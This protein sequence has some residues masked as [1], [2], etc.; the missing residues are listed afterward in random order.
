MHGP[1]VGLQ[2][3]RPVLQLYRTRVPRFRILLCAALLIN[4][5]PDLSVVVSPGD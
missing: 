3:Q 5:W 2:L 4:W 1:A